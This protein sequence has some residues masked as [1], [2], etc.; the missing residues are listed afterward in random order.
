MDVVITYVDITPSWK[1]NYNS[2]VKKD[3]EEERFRSYGVLDLQ[4]KLIRKYMSWVGNIFVVVSD[5]DQIPEGFDKSLCTFVFH[6][7]IIPSKYL[8]CFNS[9]TIEMF[10]HKIKDLSEEFIYFN[11]DIF[12]IDYISSSLF[13]VNHKPCLSP[14]IYD[15]KE[16]DG[17][18]V[19]NLIN[20]TRE[21]AKYTK[22]ENKFKDKYIKYTHICRPL[23]K[24]R[25]ESVF[26]H[27]ILPIL[28]SLTRTRHSK[29]FNTT[30]FHNYDY[31]TKNY[32]E[33]DIKYSYIDL[34]DPE[35][36]IDKINKKE[37]PI[38]CINDINT[39]IDFNEFKKELRKIFEANLE[40]KKY[41]KEV[42]KEE[43][44][45]VVNII[46]KLVVSFTSWTKRI[47]YCKKCV[48]NILS[49]TIKPDLIYLNLSIEEFPNKENDL[50][51]DLVELSNKEK[52]FIINWVEGPNTKTFKKV[53]PILQYLNDEDLIFWTDEDLILPQNTLESRIEDFK[54]YNQPISGI[55]KN[56]SASVIYKKGFNEIFGLNYVG[57]STACSIA[58]VKMLKGFNY[59]KTDNIIK[60]FNDD[61][62]YATLCYLN[63]YNFHPC[64]DCSVWRNRDIDTKNFVKF[65]QDDVALS[66]IVNNNYSQNSIETLK[67]VKLILEKN[68]NDIIS[69]NIF[70]LSRYFS[71][72]KPNIIIYS[73]CLNNKDHKS[74]PKIKFYDNNLTYIMYTDDDTLNDNDIVDGWKII[75]PNSKFKIVQDINKDIKWHPF[76]ISKNGNYDISMYM[77]SKV[78]VLINPNEIILDIIDNIKF[79]FT[80][81][82]YDYKPKTHPHNDDDIYKHIDYLLWFFIE[83]QKNPNYKYKNN[84]LSWKNTLLFENYPENS[85]VL[86][87][88]VV[89]TN[90]YNKQAEYLENQI[91]NKYYEVNTLRDQ[92]VLPYILWKNNIKIKDCGLLGNY[93]TD[94]HYFV[95]NFKTNVN[96]R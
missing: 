56:K 79:G 22:K 85:G 72:I 48:E 23:L 80:C 58:Q 16:D 29:N 2:Y 17:I 83:K 15:I 44:K 59:I 43:K 45:E 13:F 25:C 77:D 61:I 18:F 52:S 51:K 63:G 55:S 36:V 69:N 12:V 5:E 91:F 31:I 50:P 53:F 94:K 40:G 32:I 7:D 86:E 21:I 76:E 33:K 3:L 67:E 89:I 65:I 68:K 88:A 35:K 27:L 60:L 64:S 14:S 26:N 24:S 62:I 6:K 75:K 28:N 19:K 71:F 47:Q 78:D 54:K 87:T 1:E 4:I 39:Y 70:K 81:S 73:C 93:C 74:F 37:N 92:I 9:C 42:K 66:K 8:P 82:I 10:I 20:S 38:I 11:D 41:V 49:Q 95:N 57:G 46:G 96:G 34:I 30:L 90:L 84:M